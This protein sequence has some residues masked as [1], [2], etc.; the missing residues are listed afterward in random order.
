MFTI[1]GKLL[2][3][4]RHVYEADKLRVSSLS[5]YHGKQSKDKQK[6]VVYI[7]FRG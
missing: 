3:K 4:S 1:F 2:R 5:N 7:K 6:E